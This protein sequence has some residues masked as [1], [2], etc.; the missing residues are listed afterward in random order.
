MSGTIKTI[1]SSM[2]KLGSSMT[3]IG[4]AMSLA[5]TTPLTAL[6]KDVVQTS[7]DFESAFAGVR[8]TVDATEDEYAELAETIKGMTLDIPQ[9]AESL[10]SIME[11]G[12][13]LGIAKDALGEFTETIAAMGVATN[14]TTEEASSMFAQ[15]A[16]IMG[17]SQSDFDRLGSTV[18]ALGN[19]FATTEADVMRMAMRMASV[20]N[21]LNMSEADVLAFATAMS[22]VGI[23]AEVG[24]SS[25]STFASNLQLAVATNSKSLKTYASVAGMTTKEFKKAFEEDATSAIM[26]FITGLG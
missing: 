15:F 17:M 16:N 14:L 25:F 10:S 26:A 13:Q 3:K 20:G 22:S 2:E 8:K 19:N 12:G 18:V 4:G 5:V 6:A 1:E 9:T 11:M 21:T 23:L 24:G 7:I